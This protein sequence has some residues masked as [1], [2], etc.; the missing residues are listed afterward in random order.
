MREIITLGLLEVL[1]MS[2]AVNTSNSL[3]SGFLSDSKQQHLNV[4]TLKKGNAQERLI[5]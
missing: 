4:R 1:D 5:C 2:L 3:T